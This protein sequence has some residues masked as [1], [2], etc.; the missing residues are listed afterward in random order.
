MAIMLDHRISINS[1]SRLAFRFFLQVS[2]NVVASAVEP[3]EERLV[4]FV[5]PTDEVE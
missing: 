1:A 3:A 4:S 2:E 5:L